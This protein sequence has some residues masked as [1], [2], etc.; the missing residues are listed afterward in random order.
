MPSYEHIKVRPRSSDFDVLSQVFRDQEYH[1]KSDYHRDTLQKSY[2]SI[3][4]IGRT[5]LIIDAGANI[6]AVV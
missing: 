6:G 5:P 4:D 2:H 1:I 3:I